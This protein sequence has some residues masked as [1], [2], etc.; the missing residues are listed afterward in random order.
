MKASF[1]LE[2]G[3]QPKDIKVCWWCPDA[4]RDAP[5][6]LEHQ[7]K[8]HGYVGPAKPRVAR[9]ALRSVLRREGQTEVGK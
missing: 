9:G 2:L 6:L 3:I 1:L 8:C 7:R 5:T 4:Y